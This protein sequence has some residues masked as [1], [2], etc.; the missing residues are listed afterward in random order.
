MVSHL[1]ITSIKEEQRQRM[2]IS[3]HVI[4]C[5]IIYRQMILIYWDLMIDSSIILM[6]DAMMLILKYAK[7]SIISAKIEGAHVD[8]LQYIV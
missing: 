8:H 3:Y 6:D 5:M 7:K 4:R 2:L 1:I